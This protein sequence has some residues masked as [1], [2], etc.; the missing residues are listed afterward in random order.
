MHYFLCNSDRYALLSIL[1]TICMKWNPMFWN[2]WTLTNNLDVNLGKSAC[3]HSEFAVLTIKLSWTVFQWNFVHT[4]WFIISVMLKYINSVYQKWV[5]H[6][7]VLKVF[8]QNANYF[9]ALFSFILTEERGDF[10]LTTHL[11]T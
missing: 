3:C 2:V 7:E 6:T 4:V 1:C 11:Q 9:S 5:A 8:V 10:P